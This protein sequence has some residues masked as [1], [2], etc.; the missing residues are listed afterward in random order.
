[1]S[2]HDH[3]QAL[4]QGFRL[5][6]YRVVRVLGVGGF[7]I[8]YLCEH[9]GLGVQVAVKEYLPNEI[10][11][12][13]GTEV[14]PKS[15]GDREGFDWGLSRFL[16]EARTLARFEHP[17]VVRVRDCFEANN[18]AYIVMDYEDGE[19]LDAL[20]RRHGT[21]TEAQLKRVL[22]PVADG[23]RQVHAAGFLHRDIKPSNIFVRR[24]DESPVLLD[25]GSA[26]QAL[27]HKSR[28]LTAIAS[29]GYSPP[30]Q[31][32][33]TAPQGAWTDIY[34]LSA[35]CYRA[36]TGNMPMSAPWRQSELLRAQRDPLP[37][38][39]ETRTA[40]YSPTFLDAVDWGLRLIETERPQSVD[41]WLPLLEGAATLRQPRDAGSKQ[42]H[43]SA[44]HPSTLRTGKEKSGRGSGRAVGLVAGLLLAV[45]IVWLVARQD[46][47][48]ASAPTLEIAA[49]LATSYRKAAE[50]GD[51][52]AQYNLGL[53]YYLG[54]GVP[55]D[56]GQAVLLWRNA[57][58]QG[59]AVAQR[60]LAIQ[61]HYGNGVP[62]E[63]GQ[64]VRWFRKAAEQGDVSAQFL[65]GDL[66]Y[67]GMGVPRDVGQTVFWVRKAAEEGYASAQHLLGVLYEVGDGTP[68]DG[69]QAE[70]WLR[71]AAEQGYAPALSSLG[72]LYASGLSR[73]QDTVQS[74]I[75]YR[76]FREL[77]NPRAQSEL[78]FLYELGKGAPKD[79]DQAMTWYRK[80]AEQ[81]DADAQYNLGLLYYLG[82]D[83]PQDS[84]QA[85]IWWRKAA[86]Q[87]D[88]HAL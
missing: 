2:A 7:G 56:A 5:G 78:D 88:A 51:A 1:M 17:N 85:A 49:T 83:V 35:L 74:E 30:E 8:T 34:A 13:D 66:Y 9:A 46:A 86:E 80:A 50:Q 54:D 3:K 60:L 69:V 70:R 81:R 29:A 19:P 63:D 38:L 14:H 12:R 28:S 52:D 6:P 11:V 33:G 71:K 15:A 55:L 43:Q 22:L 47:G 40:N 84:T 44:L 39:A 10:A 25:F 57:A 20:L 37:R 65:L 23:L 41:E 82:D 36:I 76:K 48:Q 58:E 45:A 4:R 31:Y 59:H 72:R 73:I 75:W 16:D 42:A 79:A 26:R 64:A 87:E 18:T 21:L 27:G 32:E 68:R 61:Y 53:L 77:T 67:V 62:E 24:S